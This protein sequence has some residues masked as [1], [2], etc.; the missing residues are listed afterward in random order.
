MIIIY[1]VMGAFFYF[2]I[3]FSNVLTDNP[4]SGNAKASL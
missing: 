3:H 4:Q 1:Y 2:G